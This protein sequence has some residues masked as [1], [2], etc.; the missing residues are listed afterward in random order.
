MN[1]AGF[2]RK[3]IKNC[4]SLILTRIENSTGESGIPDVIGDGD[5][6]RF[7]MELKFCKKYPVRPTTPVRFPHF[8]DHQKN[9]LY[10]HG[11]KAGYCWLSIQVEK[12]IYIFDW[13]K[14]RQVGELTKSELIDT[15]FRYYP[16][17]CDWIDFQK[18]LC[19][20]VK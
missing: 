3:I 5:M 4:T 8:S 6:V 10:I 12:D 19:T 2:S 11:K 1:E 15:S 18:A 16:K 7:W 13:R 17:R 14:Q 9:F 20:R